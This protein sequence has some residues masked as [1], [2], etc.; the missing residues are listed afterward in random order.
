VI[1]KGMG[2]AD[3]TVRAAI[4]VTAV[5]AVV[6]FAVLT[7][8]GHPRAGLAIDLGL[9]VGAANGPLIQRTA[10]LGAAFGALAFARLLVL[11]VLGLGLGLLLGLD[12]LWLVM[13]GLAA[14]QLALAFSA[15][16]RVLNG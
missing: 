3:P 10:Q 9:V 16:W 5:A 4:L 13:V 8:A 6:A 12:V 15:V 11:T 14:A 7:L 2:R 1:A